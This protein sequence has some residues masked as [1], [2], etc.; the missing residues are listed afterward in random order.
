[1]SPCLHSDQAFALGLAGLIAGQVAC[2]GSMSAWLVGIAEHAASEQCTVVW[3]HLHSNQALALVGL[4][5][6]GVIAEQVAALTPVTGQ[7]VQLA[8]A[9]HECRCIHVQV[10]VILQRQT[11]CQSS[12]SSTRH[13]TL[14]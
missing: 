10:V 3:L 5:L 11:H 2:A 8:S 9:A 1:M 7:K 12:C 4:G 13:T 14:V 6:A